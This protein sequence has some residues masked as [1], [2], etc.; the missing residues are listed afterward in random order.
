[1]NVFIRCR[2]CAHENRFEDTTPSRTELAVF[3]GSEDRPKCKS[4]GAEMDPM[5][6]YLGEQVGLEIHR[7]PDP[8]F[9]DRISDG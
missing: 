3:R 2:E 4:C 7:L 9:G 1:M 5:T 8:K 6:A